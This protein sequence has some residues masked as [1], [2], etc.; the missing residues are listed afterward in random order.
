MESVA[1]R[2][3]AGPQQHAVGST[4]IT[5]WFCR[6]SSLTSCNRQTPS[7]LFKDLSAAAV[8]W[9]KKS[10]PATLAHLR[11]RRAGVSSAVCLAQTKGRITL[12][13]LLPPELMVAAN[14]EDFTGE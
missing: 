12:W 11:R 10:T 1:G 13:N 9:I 7:W 3:S 6:P 5:F 8:M 2:F 14:A 4:W